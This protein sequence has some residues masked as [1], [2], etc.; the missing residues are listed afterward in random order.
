M[1]F[2]ASLVFASA[3]LFLATISG[4][5]ISKF[6]KSTSENRRINAQ[7]VIFSTVMSIALMIAALMIAVTAR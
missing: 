1:S 3:S 7:A 2:L 6:E 5:A 4:Y